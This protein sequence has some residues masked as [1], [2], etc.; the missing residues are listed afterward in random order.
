MTPEEI[1]V[2]RAAIEWKRRVG[3]ANFHDLTRWSAALDEVERLTSIV[4]HTSELLHTQR[5]QH[6]A[7]IRRSSRV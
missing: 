6:L 1:A 2:D 7:L 4:E 3:S 5:V